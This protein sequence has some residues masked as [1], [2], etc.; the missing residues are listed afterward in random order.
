MSEIDTNEFL[1][2][3]SPEDR[4]AFVADMFANMGS[5]I[6]S[7]LAASPASVALVSTVVKPKR[8]GSRGPSFWD[9]LFMDVDV[10]DSIAIHCG[11]DGFPEDSS[12]EKADATALSERVFGALVGR[13]EKSSVT[14]TFERRDEDGRVHKVRLVLIDE[15]AKTTGAIQNKIK[16]IAEAADEKALTASVTAALDSIKK[17]RALPEQESKDLTAAVEQTRAQRAEALAKANTEPPAPPAPP[18]E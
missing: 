13:L 16:N 17:A 2:G 8:T 15:T 1:K 18:A 11:V 5:E 9:L 7:H 12:D 3:L 14:G 10:L 4:A 6:T